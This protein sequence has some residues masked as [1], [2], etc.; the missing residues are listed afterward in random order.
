MWLMAWDPAKYLRFEAQRLRPALDLIARVDLEAP[1]QIADLGCG[2]GNISRI[3]AERWPE[4]D[5]LGVDSSEEMLAKAR[6]GSPARCRWER[7]DLADWVPAAGR[8]DLIFS[9]AAL[10]W[11]DRHEV[12]L[13]RLASLLRPGGLLAVQMPRNHAAPSHQ[14]M[15]E[16][17]SA[18]PWAD[19]VV[20]AL[21]P[22]PVSSA[23]A[24]FAILAP[25]AEALDLW[26]TEY[27]HV[28]PPGKE[29]PVVAW[30]RG[31]ALRPLLDAAGPHAEAFLATYT[32]RITHAYPLL[33]DGRVLFP[34]RRLF[35][36]ARP[37]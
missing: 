24:C 18:G 4:A 37:R 29:H 33:P 25:H 20:P 19:R 31:T 17:A 12:L 32:E 6:E 27:L 11:L 7:A 35:L 30:T 15:I 14:A 13:P 3:L 16:A 8:P 26:E 5:V 36:I 23:S 28:L 1:A 21:R 22:S 2:T 34:F 9:N 10:H